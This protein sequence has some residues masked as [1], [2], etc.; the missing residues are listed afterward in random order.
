MARTNKEYLSILTR[1]YRNH[2]LQETFEKNPL[3]ERLPSIQFIKSLRRNKPEKTV[4][5]SAVT[6]A[7]DLKSVVMDNDTF[8][9]QLKYFA[10][11][12]EQLQSWYLSRNP[13]S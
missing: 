6:N 3:T 2:K 11:I 10:F 7:I 12:L 1:A 9:E 8:I 13:N 4:F 5:I